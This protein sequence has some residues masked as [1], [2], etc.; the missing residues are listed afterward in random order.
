MKRKLLLLV[1]V[2]TSFN[3]IIGQ[4]SCY[5]DNADY[6]TGSTNGI[7]FTQTSEIHAQGNNAERG[8]ARF[9]TS[10]IPDGDEVLS[11]ELHIYINHNNWAFFKIMSMENDPLSGDAASVYIDAGDGT[12]YTTYTSNFPS[13]DWYVVDL[14]ATA[15]VDLKNRL[16]D[17]WFAIGLY[18][19]DLSGTP[20]LSCDGWN[21]TN[22]PYIVVTHSAPPSCLAPSALAESNITANSADLSWTENNTATTWNIKWGV[23]GFNPDSE[24]TLISELTGNPYA[25][26]GLAANTT[27]DW[28]VQS[29]C[30]SGDKSSWAGPKTFTTLVLAPTPY[31]EG[32]TEWTLPEGW[33]ATNWYIDITDVIAPIA[34]NYI[35]GELYFSA[36]LTLTTVNIGPVSAGM[37]LSF[38]Y[39]HANYDPPYP[40]P[41]DGS[42]NFVVSISDDYGQNYSILETVDNNSIVEWQYKSYDLSAYAGENV[43]IKITANRISSNYYLA[44][45]N[46]SVAIPP[47]CLTPST[48]I[49]SNIT[50]NSADLSWTENGTA[51]SWNIKWGAEGFDPDSEGTLITG[52][53]NNSHPLSGLATNASYDWYVQSD[54]GSGDKSSWA[55]PKTFATQNISS[56]PYLE[57]FESMDIPEGWTTIGWWEIGT[58]FAIS[59]INGS[60]MY[61]D[62]YSSSPSK[63]FTTI[64]IGP[65]SADMHLSFDYTHAV[66]NDPYASPGENSGD[67]VV[68]IS[69]NY[70]QNH[71]ILE[72]VD[73]NTIS[74][75]QYKSYDLSAYIGENVKI[76][77][78]ANPASDYFLAFD[79]F[80][81]DIPP[82][83]PTP[84]TLTNANI[85]INSADLSWTEN[86][87]AT[88]WNL[89][90]KAGADFTPGN[91]ESD[92]EATINTT[93]E[94]SLAGLTAGTTYYWYVRADC[95]GDDKSSWTG[96]KTFTTPALAPTPYFE[97]FA[98]TTL[99]EGWT[100][101]GWWQIGRT[102]AIP[103]VNGNYIR[104][105]LYGNSPQTFTTI[106]IG[107]VSAGMHLSFDYAHASIYY[108]YTPP[109]D[110]SGNFVVSISKDY[111]QTF[112][113]LGT[114]ENNT[115]A[116]WQSKSYDLNDYVGEYVKIKIT[117]NR[118]SGDYWLAFDGFSIDIPPS[119]PAPS[120]LTETNTTAHTADLSWTENG[121]ATTWIVEWKAGADF[122]PGNSES[123]GQATVNGSP[124]HSLTDLTIYTVY[125][126]YVRADCGDDDKSLWIGPKTFVTPA[127]LP[128]PYT[129]SFETT[130][131]PEGWTTTYW[132]IGTTSAIPAIDG[133]YIRERFY[134]YTTSRTLTTINVGPV[135][136]DMVLNFDYTF[137]N[138]SYPYAPP[139]NNSGYFSVYVSK[140][141]G[142]NYTFLAVIS[143]NTT[144]GWKSISYD[145]NAYIDENVKIKIVANRNSG[146]YYLAFDNF[147]IASCLVPTT[148]TESDI[149]GESVDL[150]WTE[151]GTA[152]N[153]KV[154]W[155]EGADFTPGNSE[156]DGEATVSGGPEHTLTGLSAL[157]T[158][159]WYVKADCGGG[160]ESTWV[161]PA[162]FT[163][164]CATKTAPWT[165]DFEAHT[166]TTNATWDNCWSASPAATTSAFRWNLTATGKTPSYYTGPNVAHSGTKFA[167][168]EA[169]SGV[170]GDFAALYS[171]HID[172]NSLTSPALTF[173]YYMYGASIGSLYVDIHDGTSWINAVA[174]ITGQQQ[175]NGNQP[176]IEEYVNI[177]AYS[178]TIRVRFRA[179]RGSG[180]SGDIA[181]DD[182]S[183]IEAPACPAPKALTESNITVNS[184]YLSWTENG[185]ASSWNLEWNATTDF[186]PGS[187]ES[188]GQTTVNTYPEHSL[189]GLT[190]NTTYYWYVKADCGGESDWVGPNTFTTPNYTSA[191]YIEGFETT[192][193]PIGWTTTDWSIGTTTAIPAIENN[194]I[195]AYLTSYYTPRTFTTIN[196][197]LISADMQLSFYYAHANNNSPYPSPGDGS[198]N[199]VVSVSDDYG[200]SYTDLETVDNNNTAG[201][202]Y[203]SYD[204]TDFDGEYVNIKITANG[205]SGSYY[206][207]FD[208]FSVAIPPSCLAPSVLTSSNI[209]GGSA[210]LGWTEIG[211]A[212]NW[213]IKW[214]AEDFDPDT[215]GTLI[216]N[217]TNPYT[218]SGL[219][220]N[221]TY[222]WYVQSDCGSGDK[223][224]WAG[225]KSFTTYNLSPAPYTQGF[226]TTSTP[227]GWV[228]AGWTIGTTEAIPAIDGNYI[229]GIMQYSTP[230]TFTTINVGPVSV[231]MHLS[232][233]YAHANY[234]SP[235]DPPGN[236]SGNF[237]VSVSTDYGQSYTDLETV[238]NNTTAG[239]QYKSYDLNTYVGEDVKI[240]ITA[241]RTSV[242]Y[243][244]AFDNLSIAIPQSCLDPTTLTESN[245]TLNSADLSWTE[246]GTA[247]SWNIKWDTEDFDPDAEG[248]LVSGVTNPYTLS[249]LVQNT[250]YYWYVQADCGSGDKSDWVGPKT[251]TTHSFSP[252]PYTQDFETRPEGWT[253]TDWAIGTTAAIPAIDGNYIRKSLFN[254]TPQT[255]TTINIGTVSADMVLSF[256]YAH[257]GI[258]SPYSPPGDGSGNFAVSVSTDY[259]QSYTD[260][261]TVNNNTTAFWQYKSYDLSAYDGKY[262]KVKITAKSTSY[263]SYYL[264]FDN[265]S[266]AVP[267]SCLAPTLLVNSNITEA[268]A[269]LGWTENGSAT[270]W[271]IKWAA[272]DFDPDTEGTLIPNVTNPYAFSGLAPN[273]TYYWYVQ[274]DCGGDKSDWVGPDSFTTTQLVATLPFSEDFETWPNSWTVV[275]NGTQTNQWH[276]GTATAHGGS[277]AAYISDDAGTSNSYNSTKHSVVH[278]YIDIAFTEGSE[279]FNL[280]FWWKG[281]GET[282]YDYMRVYVVETSYTPTAGTLPTS[283]QIGGNF[284]VTS[285]WTLAEL[286]LP[287]DYSGT[288]KRLVFSWR[289]DGSAGLDPPA[290]ID[291]ITIRALRAL[292]WTGATSTDWHDAQNWNPA[293]VPTANDNLTI[294]A[295]LANYPTIS[296]AASCNDIFLQSNA[297]GTASLL[298]NGLLTVNGN[299]T[300]QRYINGGGYHFVSVPI[301]GTL[302]AG[303]FMNSYLYYYD[304]TA[305][306]QVWTGVG[307]DPD[308]TITNDQGYMI[309]YTGNNTTYNFSG[310]LISGAF[311]T[312][313]PSSGAAQY[314]YNLVPNPY[315][316]PIDWDAGTGWTKTKLNNAIYIWNRAKA[317]EA[318]PNGQYA[319]YVNGASTNDGSRY[320]PM[321]QSFFVETAG[322]GMPSLTMNND[323]RVHS[324]QPFYKSNQ[325]IPELLRIT[326]ATENGNDEI[327]VRLHPDATPEFDRE[328]DASKLFG[329]ESLPQLYSLTA[330]E[331]MLSINT[332]PLGDVPVV[333]PVGFEWPNKA[334]VNLKI[335]ELESFDPS[336]NIFLE[337]LLSGEM[338]DLREQPAY[339]FMHDESYEA[340]RFN[341]HFIKDA[342]AVGVDEQQLSAYQVWSYDS[343]VYVSI[344]ALTGD[345]AL[346]QLVDA[347]GKVVYQGEHHLSNPEII[348]VRSNQQ[349]LIARVITGTQV[350]TQKIFI[351]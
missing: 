35:F 293:L 157:T 186:T 299:A 254:S 142:I 189:T 206:L 241:N 249:G 202:Q 236:G 146:D 187:S 93:P 45:D 225:P 8:W 75:W 37:H 137:A 291:D 104:N 3:W 305:D 169:N 341:L 193:R 219:D 118:L 350:Y 339:S 111:G 214:A 221:T 31:H 81:I 38:D 10:A 51:T 55:G 348:H 52:L 319:T 271:N 106:N 155:K 19:Y 14:G 274:A 7:N 73:N 112:T 266:V 41:G 27:Y 77:I 99:P 313:T 126:W 174:T 201:W 336:I 218:L 231:G 13:P 33:T 212:T 88:S 195:N 36:P 18:E 71:S 280:S 347:Q 46:L 328:Y 181:I 331:R 6:N 289:N 259:G 281:L 311:T 34:G 68:S 144:A 2:L 216:P 39:A 324:D 16:A 175:I 24:G 256:Y 349:V 208:D 247:T 270:S 239:W 306:P 215:E 200:Q 95:G 156:S 20:F 320:I 141:L 188:D 26:S 115:T 76:K 5:P 251:F 74:G 300:I 97:G 262:V 42:G 70:G 307:S 167:Y 303:L 103:T 332:I 105:E 72:T 59:P 134:N 183:I 83:C 132:T 127:L 298:D 15:A 138:Y 304:A 117:A 139:T 269:D 30:G 340:L 326:S 153:W 56:T 213:N 209:T 107:P 82:S 173:Y 323:V 197:G 4:T 283:G 114:V 108:P 346:I 135:S 43:K 282:A 100:T 257:A 335:T 130:T 295:G 86:G 316:S 329:S 69:D 296:S 238:D 160:D 235:F 315:P 148:L 322:G 164:V 40:S 147:S 50:L 133:N 228:T 317:T 318:N 60:Y 65:V 203:K 184:A 166:A 255:F 182:F 297:S 237:I 9:N 351:R 244:L 84:I 286:E 25:L 78:T 229:R 267:A 29:D 92:G 261:E 113:D 301:N 151:K 294:P 240:K 109:G 91:L 185:S 191:P 327:V 333:V 277:Q 44:F 87:T 246:I 176:W 123:D 309:W 253:T 224:D 102:S 54:C 321:G 89:E 264:A 67:F 234:S 171:P 252:A 120:A 310:S 260:L 248:T 119:C 344:P 179:E 242:T 128:A 172:V 292:N 233:Y 47:S 49:T 23:D 79:N 136:A 116:G 337:D 53:T 85:T 124:E 149:S 98:T 101:T 198:G 230:R 194:Y 121:S 96:P 290:A 28:Y 158:Y 61:G 263:D 343:K 276:V 308:A 314:Q 1:F 342:V 196:I 90:W 199:F 11:V 223:S 338:I 180:S 80:S 129:Q 272:E 205:I 168:T 177:S 250:T 94:H 279:K 227:D 207:A 163:T 204:L 245:I 312:A 140:D 159:Y 131:P 288:T 161:G 57:D 285:D 162:S 48:L 22:K 58:V 62:F 284:N 325:Q 150:S 17:D 32:F 145:L 63:T 217:V 152:T 190:A 220:P 268:S 125:Y 211:A 275:I 243:L 21:E 278:T 192:T 64:N 334:E 330:D 287:G 226:T 222:Y 143:N 154:E 232:F 178:G 170:A 273:T 210:D 265:F 302:T 66:Y 12:A 345:K 258:Y 165:D 122:T 110:G